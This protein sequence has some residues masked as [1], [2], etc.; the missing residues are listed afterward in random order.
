MLQK[1]L[2]KSKNC[3]DSQV[4]SNNEP[5]PEKSVRTQTRFVFLSKQV[6]LRHCVSGT[7]KGTLSPLCV[8]YPVNF[9]IDEHS[10]KIFKPRVSWKVQDLLKNQN[11]KNL[12]AL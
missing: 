11:K 6:K 9:E 7:Q 10:M 2:V 1:A 4:K 5:W 12:I 8:R 3:A